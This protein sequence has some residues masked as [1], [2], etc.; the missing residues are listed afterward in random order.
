M[1]KDKVQDIDTTG[2]TFIESRE[3]DGK[4][5]TV[6]AKA[7]PMGCDKRMIVSKNGAVESDDTEFKRTAYIQEWTIDGKPFRYDLIGG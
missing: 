5:V 6:Y 2:F 7:V 1:A 3:I 4:V